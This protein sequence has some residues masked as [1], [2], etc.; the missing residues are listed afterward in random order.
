MEPGRI[1]LRDEHDGKDHRHLAAYLDAE[2]NLHVDGQDL[3]PSTAQ[4]SGDGEYE[5][6]TIILAT[7][8]PQ[9]S[10]ALGGELVSIDAGSP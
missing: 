4:V 3:G 8:L 5:W 9:L 2:G 1:T 6:F 7:Q 10:K